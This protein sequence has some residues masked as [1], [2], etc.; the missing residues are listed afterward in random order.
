MTQLIN[1]KTIAHKIEE[2][3]AG[4]IKTFT[5]RPPGLAFILVGDAPASRSYI[6]AKK[7]KCRDVGILSFDREFTAD[8]SEVKLLDE[9]AH[10]NK[11]P[12]VDGI[13]IQLPLPPHIS[14]TRIMEAVSPEKDVDGFH[15]L[16]MGK[17]LIGENGGFFPCTPLGIIT[18]LAHSKIAVSGKHVVIVGR[19]NIVGK[20]LAALLMQKAPHCNATVTLA[21]SYTENLAALC[22]SA[23]ILIAALGKPHSITREMTNE[24]MII[25]DVGI[26][27]IKRDD[28]EVLVGDVDFAQIAPHVTAITPVP[29]GVGPMTIAM[30]L[31]NTLLSY[32]RREQ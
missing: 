8:V 25:V 23:D 15:P 6:E 27:R 32:Q 17:M 24:R 4:V 29:G 9:I 5:H 28:K 31:S 13:L 26:N 7:K 22:R 21:H 16:N 18:L 10:L 3:I 19:S 2:E 14:S 20:P 11:N 1:G 30:L 12:A